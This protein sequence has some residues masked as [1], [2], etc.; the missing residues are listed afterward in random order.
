MLFLSTDWKKALGRELME[1]RP[2]CKYL[3]LEE[4]L[5]PAL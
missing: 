1:L 3:Q 2:H 4:E 5:L